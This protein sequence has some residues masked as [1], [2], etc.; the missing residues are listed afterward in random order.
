MNQD[1]LTKWVVEYQLTN[2]NEHSYCGDLCN[3]LEELCKVDYIIGGK[4][5]NRENIKEDLFDLMYVHWSNNIGFK[6]KLRN[7]TKFKQDINVE[8]TEPRKGHRTVFIFY[9]VTT[10]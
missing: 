4:L 9:L 2:F 5:L 3:M 10:R 1:C 7:Y 8:D 6:P